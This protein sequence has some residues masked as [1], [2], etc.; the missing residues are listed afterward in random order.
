MMPKGLEEGLLWVGALIGIQGERFWEGAF[1]ALRS[2]KD[3]LCCCCYLRCQ[4]ELDGDVDQGVEGLI[5]DLVFLKGL[6]TKS[7]V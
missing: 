4:C 6:K 5:W 7:T 2:V 1:G 3:L